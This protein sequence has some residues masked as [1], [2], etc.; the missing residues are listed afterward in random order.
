MTSIPRRF[1]ATMLACAGSSRAIRETPR[2]RA[3][4]TVG[5]RSPTCASR[6]ICG[7]I[8]RGRTASCARQ[9][10]CSMPVPARIPGCIEKDHNPSP[11][12]RAR[13]YGAAGVA[14]HAE[15]TRLLLD[16]G[17]DPNDDET[18]YHAP[19]T[20]RQRRAES[21]RRERKAQSTIASRPCCLRKADW[22][23]YAGV[24]WLLEHGADPNR[25]TRWRSTATPSSGA[26]R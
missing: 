13:I 9:R 20:L 7:S 12:S 10:R 26:A 16:R 25:K 6:A 18:P 5:T 3:A 1:W 24:K 19:E 15:L 8:A 22:H 4:R 21:P 23:D 11:C 2:R 14:H 17:A